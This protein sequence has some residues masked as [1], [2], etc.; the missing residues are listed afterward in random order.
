MRQRKTRNI[1]TI[2][3]CKLFSLLLNDL[4]VISQY[5]KNSKAEKKR[6]ENPEENL[7]YLQLVPLRAG[8]TPSSP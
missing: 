3:K 1:Y 2:K 6:S 5:E 4:L 8:G 7:K